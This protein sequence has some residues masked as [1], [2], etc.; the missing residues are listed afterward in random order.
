MENYSVTVDNTRPKV[1]SIKVNLPDATSS[2]GKKDIDLYRNEVTA[3]VKTNTTITF[4]ITDDKR[5]SADKIKNSIFVNSSKGG[6]VPGTIKSI[7]ISDTSLDVIFTPDS[8]LAGSTTYTML[9]NPFLIDFIPGATTTTDAAGN[10]LFPTIRKFST[11]GAS[12]VKKARMMVAQSVVGI[13]NDPHGNYTNNTNS[14]ATCHNT[15]ASQ[16]AELEQYDSTNS[17]YN[18][19]T[20]SYNYCMA[21]HDGTGATAPENIHQNNHF[22]EYGVAGAQ[23]SAGDCSSCHN[24]HLPADHVDNPKMLRDHFVVENHPAVVGVSADM[25]DSD[26]QLCETCHEMDSPRVKNYVKKDVN[27]PI[28]V[29]NK[30]YDYRIETATGTPDDFALCIR[31]HDGTKKWKDVDGEPVMISNIKQFYD[32]KTETTDTTNSNLSMHRI[33]ALDSGKLVKSSGTTEN[34]GHIPCGEC[35]DTHGSINIKFL[36]DKL[37]D[38]DRRTFS[39]ATGSWDGAKEK[40]FCLTCHND[41]VTAIYGVKA[42]ALTATS[43]GHKSTDLRAC[44]ECHGTGNNLAEKAMSAVHA[45]MAGTP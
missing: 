5:V 12:P 4:T 19:G 16:G 25:F 3:Y 11:E 34:D 7:P 15:H 6:N 41:G 20:S 2:T 8:K 40:I 21:C 33:T 44:S 27:D 31:C 23:A 26:K 37:G 13:A 10:P 36:N 1:T 22:P 14:C 32:I 43:D 18:S 28:V 35:H 17:G 45:P 9:I 39:A 29:T 38:E 24:P 30:V 42:K